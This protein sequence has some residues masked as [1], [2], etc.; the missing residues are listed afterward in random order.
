M[1]ATSCLL[2]GLLQ[3]VYI[4]LLLGIFWQAINLISSQERLQPIA[5]YNKLLRFGLFGLRRHPACG[6]ILRVASMRQ[7]KLAATV[8]PSV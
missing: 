4:L 7:P 2:C 1:L 8:I 5:G 3:V 6:L